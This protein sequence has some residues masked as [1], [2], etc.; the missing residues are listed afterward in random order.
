MPS[1]QWVVRTEGSRPAVGFDFADAWHG[2]SSLLVDGSPDRPVT[3]DL[4][5][6][7]LPLG[8]D[9]VV[10]LTHRAEAGHVTVEL[11]VAT[12]EPAA[13]GVAHPYTCLP[14]G[15]AGPGWAT[16]TVRL[17]GLTGTVHSLGVRITGDGGPLRWHL[18]AP[19]VRRGAAATP[20]APAAL[21]VTDATAAGLRFA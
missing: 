1:S 19:A 4:Y 10:E 5:A 14:V 11:A 7:R 13:P 2:G 15:I 6:T 16:R 8:P 17:T 21:R 20:S 9:T 18:G 12:A 3:L